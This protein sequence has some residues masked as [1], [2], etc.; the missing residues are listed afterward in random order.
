MQLA[1]F[2]KQYPQY[3]DMPDA[4]LA[5][6]LHKKYYSDI[7]YDEFSKN[8]GLTA[9]E[10]VPRDTLDKPLK[11]PE[12]TGDSFT[13][14][15]KKGAQ[16]AGV[17]LGVTM[18][19]GIQRAV[20]EAASA[21]MGGPWEE[22]QLTPEE[23]IALP[24]KGTEVLNHMLPMETEALEEARKA[25]DESRM[26]QVMDVAIGRIREDALNEKRTAARGEMEAEYPEIKTGISKQRIGTKMLQRMQPSPGTGT[27]AKFAGE[28][29]EAGLGSLA[30]MIGLGIVTSGSTIPLMLMGTGVFGQTYGQARAD[31][32][33]RNEATADALYSAAAE[34]LTEKIPLDYILKNPAGK[35]WLKRW[36]TAAGL[37]GGQEAL[38][39]VLQ[40]VYDV[41]AKGEEITLFEGIKRA[42][43][44][45]LIGAA[46]GVGG[47]VV[48]QPGQREKTPVENILDQAVNQAESIKK[49]AGISETLEQRPSLA[50]KVDFAPAEELEKDLK[51]IVDETKKPPP[52][53]AMA[54]AFEKALRPTQR[55]AEITKPISD[56]ILTH[57]KLFGDSSDTKTLQSKGFKSVKRDIQHVMLSQMRTA[58]NNTQVFKAVIESIPVDVMN[59]LIGQKWTPESLLHDKS[60]LTSRLSISSDVPIPETVITFVDSLST[61]IK[62]IPT[63]K[64]TEKPSLR[65][66]PSVVELPSEGV[67]TVEADG[68]NLWHGDIAG[69]EV[70]IDINPTEEQKKAGNYRKGA[71]SLHGL[72]ISIENPKGSVR[73]GKDKTGKGWEQELHSHY[74][75]VKRTDGADGDH[76]DVFVGDNPESEQ[77]FVVDQVDTD[78][79]RFD[80]AK[81]LLGYNSESDAREGYLANYEDGWK[82]LGKIHSTSISEFK[83]WLEHGDTK[84]AFSKAR[85]AR[86]KIP[87]RVPSVVADEGK[88]RKPEEQRVRELRGE[89]DKGLRKMEKEFPGVP[90]RYGEE[91][92]DREGMDAREEEQRR[93]V[94]SEELR[95]GHPARA[96]EKPEK[97]LSSDLQGRKKTDVRAGRGEGAGQ[98]HGKVKDKELRLERGE[99]PGDTGRSTQE[100][101]QNADLSGQDATDG[102]L[103]KRIGGQASNLE[104]QNIDIELARK[105]SIRRTHQKAEEPLAKQVAKPKVKRLA[106]KPVEELYEPGSL[107]RG[108]EESNTFE[109]YRSWVVGRFGKAKMRE[110]SSQL[111]DIWDRVKGKKPTKKQR[112]KPI[113]RITLT[114]NVNGETLSAKAGSKVVNEHMTELTGRVKQLKSVLDCLRG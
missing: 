27:I 12:A 54:A 79:G 112:A 106:Q 32:R 31:G 83:D 105:E 41:Q 108:A 24:R 87:A 45:G 49:T 23:E 102:G 71:I 63:K 9:V 92:G 36:L 15:V 48:T 69:Q 90:G 10:D 18:P 97:Q 91:A 2:R 59:V 50:E 25:G 65:D 20:G 8:I 78:T 96:G 13:E 98:A 51:P 5:T 33:S 61:A 22:I 99:R 55:E 44:E 75:Y 19:G 17:S 43:H 34:T 60:M 64:T 4:D 42:A 89:R 66:E 26:R 14:S 77:V 101:Q 67:T 81:V 6:S 82:G 53:G 62:G 57:A 88:V 85:T 56:G 40:S 111:P 29:T 21:Q 39:S 47:A 70:D 95:V 104:K 37:E 35:K 80:E 28:V 38:S 68:R 74:G 110:I 58:L 7:S 109:E 72:D 46:L 52:G 84:Q 114:Y 16:R 1:E 73:R 100:E 3:D 107:E 86:E 94:S 76:V 103:G 93:G 11:E 113:N 30:P